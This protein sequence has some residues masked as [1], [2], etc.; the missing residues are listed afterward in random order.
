MKA[1]LVRDFAP[2]GDFSNVVIEEREDP[3]PAPGQIRVRMLCAPVNPSDFNFIHGT[4]REGFERLIW[5]HGQQDLTTDAAR[6][7][8]FAMPPYVVGGEGVGVVDA[9]G[10]GLLAKRLMGKRV[11]VA[12]GPPSG[13][14]QQYTIADAIRAVAL[15]STVS[16]E[17]ASMFFVNPLSVYAMLRH[18][19]RVKPGRWLLITAAG[20]ALGKAAVRLGAKFGYRTICVVRG[21]ANSEVLRRLGAHAVIETDTQD[22][23]SEVHRITAG[24]GADY[25]LDCVGGALAGDALR[26][27]ALN[28]HYLCYGTLSGAP[29]ELHQRDIMHPLVKVEGFFL[30]NWLLQQNKLTLLRTLTAVRKLLA[31]GYFDCDVD[32][33]FDFDHVHDALAAAAARDRTGKVLLRFP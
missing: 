6:A 17:Q 24:H 1:I 13:T 10:G 3:R 27:M 20:S 21:S 32:R 26:C 15:P 8:P 4:Y 18:V 5:N 25:A 16:D 19:L 9:C 11:S 23:V 22:L 14:W 7:V 28:G 29:I 33:V 2:V 12:V 31:A 30:P